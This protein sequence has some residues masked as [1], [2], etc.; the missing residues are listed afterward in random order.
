MQRDESLM[1]LETTCFHGITLCAVD[2]ISA[3]EPNIANAKS[4]LEGD[5]VMGSSTVLLKRSKPSLE[6][7]YCARC[8]GASNLKVKALCAEG[9][10]DVVLLET[11]VIAVRAVITFCYLP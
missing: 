1:V 9:S 3:G 4:M 11:T 7:H 10:I 2:E 6:D 8:S 5:E